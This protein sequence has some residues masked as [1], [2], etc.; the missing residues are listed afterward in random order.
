MTWNPV[1][2]LMGHSFT[3]IRNY[4]VCDFCGKRVDVR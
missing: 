3:R 2:M 4:M 1:C